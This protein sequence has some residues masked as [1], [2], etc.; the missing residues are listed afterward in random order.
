MSHANDEQEAFW[1]KGPGQRWVE[2]QPDLDLL[3]GRVTDL[4]L[5]EAA[6]RPGM[7]VLDIGCGA[8]ASSFAAAG[9]VGAK[10]KK[11]QKTPLNVQHAPSLPEADLLHFD[12]CPA[13]IAQRRYAPKRGIRESW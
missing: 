13:D 6:P 9:A 5:A 7:R 2:F 12:A 3:H 8:G 4:L 1:N 11:R 10:A